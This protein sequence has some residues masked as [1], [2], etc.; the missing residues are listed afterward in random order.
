A[1]TDQSTFFG[2]VPGTRVTFRI[3][4][5]NDFLEGGREAQVYIAFIDVRGGGNAVL[6]TRQVFVVVPGSSGGPM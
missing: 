1:F 4:F 3:T 5:R 6:D 2:V